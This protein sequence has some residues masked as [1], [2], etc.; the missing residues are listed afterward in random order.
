M[1]FFRILFLFCFGLSSLKAAW[2][3]S[4]LMGFGLKCEAGIIRSLTFATG[5]ARDAE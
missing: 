3:F 4:V 5:A 2:N 1:I